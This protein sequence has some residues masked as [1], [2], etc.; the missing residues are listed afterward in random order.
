MVIK[1]IHTRFLRVF[2]SSSE[3]KQSDSDMPVCVDCLLQHLGKRVVNPR[4]P[5]RAPSPIQG[6]QVRQSGLDLLAQAAVDGG[7][8]ETT[9]AF[10]TLEP[11]VGRDHAADFESDVVSESLCAQDHRLAVQEALE[12]AA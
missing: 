12:T 9:Q 1:Y 10:C 8:N 5:T 3:T 7:R 4:P 11:V 6:R 2:R